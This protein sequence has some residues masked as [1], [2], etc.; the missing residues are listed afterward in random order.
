[1]VEVDDDGELAVTVESVTWGADGSIHLDLGELPGVTDAE[2]DEMGFSSIPIDEVV[3]F[4]DDHYDSYATSTSAPAGSLDLKDVDVTFTATPPK[5]LENV[6]LVVKYLAPATVGE[7]LDEL[8]K[9]DRSIPVEISSDDEDYDD[10]TIYTNYPSGRDGEGVEFVDL[11]AVWLRA[12]MSRSTEMKSKCILCGAD[13]IPGP[14][15]TH[16][17]WDWVHAATGLRKC[18]DDSTRA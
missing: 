8:L 5:E 10:D 18:A 17:H 1:M 6:E 2:L 7:V 4:E 14:Q 13:I 9:Y 16:G 3:P 12:A 15:D 11:Q